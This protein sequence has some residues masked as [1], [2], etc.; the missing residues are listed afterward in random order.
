MVLPEG[1][2]HAT[3][4][5]ILDLRNVH[6][7]LIRRLSLSPNGRRDNYKIKHIPRVQFFGLWKLN[8]TLPQDIEIILDVKDQI[9]S[10][11]SKLD[12]VGRSICEADCYVDDFIAQVYG[13]NQQD[14]K[15]MIAKF[16][17]ELENINSGIMNIMHGRVE[18]I[19]SNFK[20][21]F[22]FADSLFP[23]ESFSPPS[24]QTLKL[25]GRLPG[26]AQWRTSPSYQWT[27]P[28]CLRTKL[29]CYSSFP[30]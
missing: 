14:Q 29:Q 2:Q 11:I 30:N 18:R 4:L 13:R 1:L 23:P 27:P 3:T 28:I 17:S 19:R 5:Q 8:S 22:W 15:E 6:E 10:I 24:L 26:L 9:V 16:G 20:S 21:S 25:E 12:D 7:D